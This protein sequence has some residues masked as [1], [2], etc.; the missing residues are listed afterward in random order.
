MKQNKSTKLLGSNYKNAITK[1]IKQNSS[2][3]EPKK[4]SFLLGSNI[5]SQ[6]QLAFGSKSKVEIEE[7]F[8]DLDEMVEMDFPKEYNPD[9][10]NILLKELG[11]MLNENRIVIFKKFEERERERDKDRSNKMKNDDFRLL[12]CLL[13]LKKAELFE[14]VPYYSNYKFELKDLYTNNLDND[15]EDIVDIDDY[16][17]DFIEAEIQY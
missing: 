3:V 7:E 16:I 8:L 2:I 12:L 4:H 1:T 11:T 15:E 17:R 9:I 6:I 14:T 13:R 5:H 10:S